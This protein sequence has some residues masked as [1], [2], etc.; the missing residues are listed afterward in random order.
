MNSVEEFPTYIE[1]RLRFYSPKTAATSY[2]F[3]E[4]SSPKKE[5]KWTLGSLFRRKKKDESESSSDDES[6][7]GFLSKRK[8][9]GEKKKKSKP[10]GAFDH[11]VLPPHHK[12]MSSY[13]GYDDCGG[14]LSDPTGVYTYRSQR[15]PI[16]PNDGRGIKVDREGALERNEINL[17]HNSLGSVDS[18]GK[19]TRKSRAKARAEARRGD[20]PHNSSSDDDSQLSFSSNSKIR[21]E[22]NLGRHRDGSASRRS[23]GARTERYIKRLSRDEENILNREA[24]ILNRER[25]AKLEQMRQCKSDLENNLNCFNR[26]WRIC[27]EKPSKIT[28]S[29]PLPIKNRQNSNTTYQQNFTGISTIPPSHCSLK[30]KTHSSSPKSNNCTLNDS[31]LNSKKSIGFEPQS[32]VYNVRSM[33][34]D[35]NINRQ[36]TESE[37]ILHVQLP[38]RRP[39]SKRNLSLNDQ[40][41]FLQNEKQPP[42]P[43]P[44]DPR[45]VI[46]IPNSDNARPTSFC[47]DKINV[48]QKERNTQT[49]NSSQQTPPYYSSQSKAININKSR[50]LNW[51]SGIRSTSHDHIPIK[52]S[53]H[54]ALTP[55]PSSVTPE[56]S[57][58]QRHSRRNQH[59]QDVEQFQYLTDKNPRSRKPI[60]IQPAITAH[61]VMP[62]NQ[63]ESTK[64]ALNFWKQKEKEE[65]NRSQENTARKSYSPQM[66][67]AQTHVRTNVFL[68]SVI[69]SDMDQSVISGPDSLGVDVIDRP[70]RDPSPFKPISLPNFKSQEST[71][72]GQNAKMCVN[73]DKNGSLKKKLSSSSNL[74]NQNSSYKNEYESSN[75]K[76]DEKYV[77]TKTPSLDS[78]SEEMVKEKERKSTNL[79]DALD[80]LEAIYQSLHLGDED[81]LERAEQREISVATQKLLESKM[82]SY[83]GWIMSR[84]AMSDSSFSYEPFDAIDSPKKKKLLKRSRL[85]DKKTDDMAFRK[86]NKD[87][88]N[89]IADPQAVVSKVSYLLTSPVHGFDNDENHEQELKSNPNEPDVTLDDVVYRS[90]KHANN[91]LKVIDPQPP[92]GIPLGPITPASNSDYLHAVP[93]DNSQTIK[94]KKIPDIV[95][96]DLA[97]RNLRKDSGKEPALLPAASEDPTELEDKFEDLRKKRA[98][99]SLSA[100]IF[101]LIQKDNTKIPKT[102]I[103]FDSDGSDS[104]FAKTENL[105]DIAD[106]MEIARK[107]LRERDNKINA[108]RRA[109]LS[110]TDAKY[111]KN[112]TSSPEVNDNRSNILNNLKTLNVSS[113]KLKDKKKSGSHLGDSYLH[114]KPP[115]GLTP[116]RKSAAKEITP[117]P[118][119]R[120]LRA[121]RNE[122]YHSSLDELISAIEL[123]A[124]EASEKIDE[125]KDLEKKKNERDE[126]SKILKKSKDIPYSENYA[127]GLDDTENS[128]VSSRENGENPNEDKDFDVKENRLYLNKANMSNQFKLDLSKSKSTLE[129]NLTDI[130]TVS[131]HAKLCEKL[132]EC[133]VESTELIANAKTESQP[134]EQVQTLEQFLPESV[135]NIVLIPKAEEKDTKDNVVITEIY[136]D[137]DHEYEGISDQKGSNLPN[138]KSSLIEINSDNQKVSPSSK[139]SSIRDSIPEHTRFNIEKGISN[140]N[141]S[142]N[143]LGSPNRIGSPKQMGNSKKTS[144][145]EQDFSFQKGTLD[146]R[147]SSSNNTEKNSDNEYEGISNHDYDGISDQDYETILDHNYEII[148]EPDYDNIESEEE[149]ESKVCKSPFEE[150]KA[151]LIADFQ[152]LNQ[153]NDNTN[154]QNNPEERKSLDVGAGGHEAG[155]NKG[156]ERNGVLCDKACNNHNNPSFTNIDQNNKFDEPMYVSSCDI[157]LNDHADSE[158]S[159]GFHSN[160]CGDSAQECEEV[161]KES[162]NDVEVKYY[163]ESSEN[164]Y[165]YNYLLDSL[166]SPKLVRSSACKLEAIRKSRED[167]DKMFGIV[168]DAIEK[169]IV[170]EN[171]SEKVQEEIRNFDTNYDDTLLELPTSIQQ[172]CSDSSLLDVKFSVSSV[173]DN[174]E[175]LDERP[176]LNVENMFKSKL[177]CDEGNKLIDERDAVQ[178]LIIKE[179]VEK[180]L[181]VTKEEKMNQ[182]N[183]EEME[184]FVDERLQENYLDFKSVSYNFID[185]CIDEDITD[186][187]DNFKDSLS[188]FYLEDNINKR[189]S[190]LEMLKKYERSLRSPLVDK[191]SDDMQLSRPGCSKDILKKYNF[192]GAIKK[193][194]IKDSCSNGDTFN[195]STYKDPSEDHPLNSAWYQDTMALIYACAYGLACSYQLASL[196]AV[197]VLGLIVILFSIFSTFIA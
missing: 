65:K 139:D 144:C 82:E 148:K 77:L 182:S 37:S 150:H 21:S 19:K 155:S 90:I 135:V 132:L 16:L 114:A 109:F 125:L 179:K 70:I 95:K 17:S 67:T 163:K 145:S 175:E 166:K 86:L 94:S 117:V 85:P 69:K 189:N 97:Y 167:L 195:N 35:S 31:P 78:L 26:R 2:D 72:E 74:S 9:R 197:A 180:E 68:P 12:T 88:S 34:C 147:M 188:E 39:H 160:S 113:E 41:N 128:L 174:V 118:S 133:V 103:G 96:D 190:Q 105:T 187:G 7:K 51:N 22:E 156:G 81:L 143:Y 168:D 194:P 142:S 185:E 153:M 53:A 178:K 52:S 146:Q 152:K 107:I 48:S 141:I 106:A 27:D 15:I 110:D 183:E 18:S 130:D 84:G 60:F 162:L 87:R 11:I 99:R 43:P 169:K 36:N 46:G 24:S 8:R 6:K 47:F 80:E 62:L 149:K 157:I 112:D 170:A 32:G 28:P 159:S 101:N 20:L 124:Q 122:D 192:D 121:E 138:M 75:F 23:R 91:T 66:F 50:S 131:E 172:S 40:Y 38:V 193:T 49:I 33:S 186:F 5:K 129:K 181:G 4:H 116:E 1:E 176:G 45:R 42:P 184:E 58:P 134:E 100:N 104:E 3:P 30:Y 83:P 14:I 102:R 111:I 154:F 151:E 123:E 177:E 173:S 13:N 61:Q 158:K 140:Q 136:S 164:H 64:Q 44:R 119:P 108:T 115:R 165:T 191:E 29:P 59:Q 63:Q 196:D 171:N 10:V 161:E 120:P 127:K 93:E 57:Y 73:R 25:E 98:V 89:T 92:F 126:M 76:E 55:R 56:G 54:F 71:N 79:E 137:P